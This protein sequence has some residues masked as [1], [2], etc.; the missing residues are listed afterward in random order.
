MLS[1]SPAFADGTLIYNLDETAT[2]TVQKNPRVLAPKGKRNIYKVSS[3]EKGT[4]VTTCN[5]I[6]AG[7]VALPPALIFPRKNINPRMRVGTPPGSLIL[8][9]PTGWMNS[10]TFVEVMKH[11][12]QGS[13]SNRSRHGQPRISSFDRSTRFGK[14]VGGDS[15]YFTPTYIGK[16]SAVRRRCPCTVKI[17]LCLS[18]GVM[19]DMK[20]RMSS[21]HLRN[22]NTQ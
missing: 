4:L 12:V 8:A 21:Y 13:G 18:N 22:W 2:S 1:R 5:I 7:G 10:D 19:D 17:L 20:S 15:A 11:F 6:S 3:G 16:T 14:R 9:S